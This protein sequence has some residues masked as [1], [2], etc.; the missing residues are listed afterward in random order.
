MES[1]R[2]CPGPGQRDTVREQRL[3]SRAPRNCQQTDQ[4]RLDPAQAV[5]D[6]RAA[7]RFGIVVYEGVEPI[8]LGATF[9]VLSMARR[10]EPAIE[11]F[12][13]AE[14]PGPVRL[15]SGLPFS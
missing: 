8:D 6:D 4:A 1:R 5:S 10:I 3:T 7:M 13:V 15:A 14:R 2:F 9:G 12:L 11:M